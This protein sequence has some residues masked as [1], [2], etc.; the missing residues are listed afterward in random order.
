M[1]LLLDEVDKFFDARHITQDVADST[2]YFTACLL[3]HQLTQIRACTHHA[4]I[5]AGP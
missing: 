3:L 4:S 5:C 1:Y 2:D